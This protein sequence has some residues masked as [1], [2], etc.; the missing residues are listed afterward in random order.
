MRD[1]AAEISAAEN[2]KVA[3]ACCVMRTDAASRVRKLEGVGYLATVALYSRDAI[4]SVCQTRAILYYIL[5]IARRECSLA[6][7]TLDRAQKCKQAHK[8]ALRDRRARLSTAAESYRLDK[9][10]DVR[11]VRDCENKSVG[12]IVASYVRETQRSNLCV[13]Y[14]IFYETPCAI[15]ISKFYDS[16]KMLSLKISGY[17]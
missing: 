16:D 12:G 6:F 1:I 10:L 11:G 5:G 15:E 4:S 17:K 2:G 14:E 3:A 7:S 9:T 13:V 8:T